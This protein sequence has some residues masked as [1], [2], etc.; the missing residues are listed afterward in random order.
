MSDFV[1]WLIFHPVISCV[2]SWPQD[3]ILKLHVPCCY[4]IYWKLHMVS[5][6]CAWWWWLSWWD[7][8]VSLKCGHQQACCLSP[9]WYMSMENHGGM[10]MSTEENSWLVHLCSLAILPA[11]RSG[12]KHE[13]WAKGMRILP[14]EMFVFIL[15]SDFYMLQNLTTWDFRL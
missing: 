6:E 14:C 9:R 12:S 11:E 2:C 3:N 8:T 10:M 7:E 5:K 15:A 1:C 13:E 4:I